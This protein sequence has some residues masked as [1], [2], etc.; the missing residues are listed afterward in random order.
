MTHLSWGSPSSL[1]LPTL[2]VDALDIRVSLAAD[3][4]LDV[5]VLVLFG[6]RTASVF[7]SSRSNPSK[8]SVRC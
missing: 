5:E 6:L 2:D 7:K 4:F 1:F 8:V 3:A